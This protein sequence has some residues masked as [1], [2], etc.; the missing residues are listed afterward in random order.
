MVELWLEFNN[1]LSAITACG[2]KIWWNSLFQFS[3]FGFCEE[4][5]GLGNLS[6]AQS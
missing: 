4:I 6:L 5:F 1:T 3:A 2:N